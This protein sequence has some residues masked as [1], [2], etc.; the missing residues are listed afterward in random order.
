M[1]AASEAIVKYM[2]TGFAQK[3][4]DKF[5]SK[6]L[7]EALF[8][9]DPRFTTSV[10][11]NALTALKS[12]EIAIATERVP[13]TGGRAYYYTLTEILDEQ[14]KPESN[15]E[16]TTSVSKTGIKSVP[17]PSQ[18]DKPNKLPK[19]PVANPFDKVF[20]ELGEIKSKVN[21][22]AQGYSEIAR[23]PMIQGEV[24][25]TSAIINRLDEI[26]SALASFTPPVAETT[27]VPPFSTEL[28]I[29][30]VTSAINDR[31]VGDGYSDSLILRIREEIIEANNNLKDYMSIKFDDQSVAQSKLMELVSNLKTPEQITNPDDYK[32]GIREGIRMAVE[33]GITRI[34]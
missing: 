33:L 31:L 28:F 19:P 11:Q 7:K 23:K 5:S 3:G 18:D 34:N 29:A 1:S 10:V 30:G 13:G 2:R 15:G 25:D 27:S 21:G 22:L 6:E 17:T 24:M 16:E 8:R 4:K 32:Q 20:S 14:T 26:K 12:K 9:K